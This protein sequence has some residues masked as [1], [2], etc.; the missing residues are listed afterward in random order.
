MKHNEYY[1]IFPKPKAKWPSFKWAIIRSQSHDEYRESVIYV[2]AC[3]WRDGIL[4]KDMYYTDHSW[5]KQYIMIQ[6]NKDV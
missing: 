3:Q 6:T 2:L 4:I 5:I 1:L